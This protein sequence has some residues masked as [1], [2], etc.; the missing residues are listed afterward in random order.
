ME[1]SMTKDK[2]YQWSKEY[3]QAHVRESIKIAEERDPAYKAKRDA[4]RAQIARDEKFE[5]DVWFLP[6]IQRLPRDPE[7]VFSLSVGG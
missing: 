7:V 1:D 2:S 3:L 5:R 6:Y 4:E